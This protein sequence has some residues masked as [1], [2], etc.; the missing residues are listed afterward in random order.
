MSN[1]TFISIPHNSRGDRVTVEVPDARYS[2]GDIIIPAPISPAKKQQAF[3]ITA[4]PP[5][6]EPYLGKGRDWITVYVAEP[7]EMP[8]DDRRYRMNGGRP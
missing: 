4:T 1:K 3:Q 8:E 7:C 5:T 6:H 2:A